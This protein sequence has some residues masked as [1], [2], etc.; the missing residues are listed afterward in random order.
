MVIGCQQQEPLAPVDQ[1]ILNPTECVRPD[2]LFNPKIQ[3]TD[4]TV[5][6]RNIYVGTD[7]DMVMAAT[8]PKEVPLLAT[9]AFQMLLSTNF[10]ARA[11]L[12]ANEI[13][14]TKPDMIGLQEVYLFRVQSPGDL[15][16]GGTVLATQP[17]LDFL[18]IL[19][20]VLHTRDLDYKV[21]GVIQNTDVE[22]PVIMEVDANGNP[23][24]FNDF[25]VTDYDV[26]LAKKN[27]K[28]DKCTAA[29]YQARFDIPSM[30]TTVLRG[31]I[32]V[33]AKI[34]N[35][36]Y[37]FVNTH[38]EDATNPALLPVQLGQVAE[39]TSL[40]QN[41]DRPQIVVGDFNA[42]Y[43]TSPTYAYMV[44]NGYTDVWLNN[45]FQ[46][47]PE[48]FTYGHALDL[49]NPEAN[50]YKRID[51]V[52]VKDSERQKWSDPF[53]AIVV[54][55][56]PSNRYQNAD[57]SFLW[58]SDHGGVVAGLNFSKWHRMISLN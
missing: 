25:R 48:G 42:I 49:R 16:F 4:L 55:K 56:E 20:N 37:C 15:I 57:G 21:V 8:S 1:S 46:N 44:D 30:G 43:P 33:D 3:Q 6:T 47:N 24:L 2:N 18:N 53:Y 52:F 17:Y 28:I 29:N 19:V 54:G 23:I 34:K 26:V 12:L 40:L 9:Q 31:Y 32:M 41:Q 51:Y 58:P 36:P 35:K 13:E 39:L 5:M 11:E 38:L 50:F 14:R 22:V 27:V 10:A 45:R 7:V